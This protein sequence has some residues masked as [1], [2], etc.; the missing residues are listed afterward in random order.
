LLKEGFNKPKKGVDK[1][2]HPPI[3]PVKS[4][5]KSELGGWEWKLYDF[6]TRNFLGCISSDAKY[7][8]VKVLF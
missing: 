3:T 7:D 1:G 5:T 6:I 8:E 4:A 2:D